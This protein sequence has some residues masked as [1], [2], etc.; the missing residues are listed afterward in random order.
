MTGHVHVECSAA[1]VWTT[2]D[3]NG[4]TISSASDLNPGIQYAQTNSLRMIVDG[5]IAFPLSI[6][7]AFAAESFG[8]WE[9]HNVALVISGSQP[10]VTRD[11]HF[12]SHLKWSG[13]IEY[14][15]SSWAAWSEQPKTL[16]AFLPDLGQ[17]EPSINTTGGRSQ[18]PVI[19]IRGGSTSVGLGIDPT[20]GS[21]CNETVEYDWI[22]GGQSA[23]Y[24][25]WIKNPGSAFGC[26]QNRI[27]GNLVGA[28]TSVN[29][30]EGSA[31][32]PGALG[33]NYFEGSLTCDCPN[34]AA[35][36]ATFGVMSSSL[37]LSCS[38]NQG[39]ISNGIIFNSGTQGNYV[40]APQIQVSSDGAL[41]YDSGINNHLVTPPTW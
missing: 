30:V 33:T 18:L 37:F 17:D 21:Y 9:F 6:P 4:N 2:Y 25:I 7:I 11:T 36:Y 41:K 16:P 26:G 13:Y 12:G 14:T 31:G 3:E 1:G 23:K 8:D 24:G 15:G 35:Y 40:I 29:I 22:N 19:L 32:N 39:S 34:M 10:A 5:R 38:I 27:E 20:N 28:V